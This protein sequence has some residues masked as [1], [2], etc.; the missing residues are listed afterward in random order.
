MLTAA[1]DFWFLPATLFFDAILP[2]SKPVLVETIP[3]VPTAQRVRRKAQADKVE[4]GRLKR[5]YGKPEVFSE[6]HQIFSGAVVL[7]P[8]RQ[9]QPVSI[10]QNC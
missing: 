7:T 3:L 2:A 6:Q 9:R 5:R 4:A 1:I 8:A 10:R